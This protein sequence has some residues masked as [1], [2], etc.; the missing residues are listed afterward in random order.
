MK[1]IIR[2][3]IIMLAASALLAGISGCKKDG[4]TA[5]EVGREIDQTI[6]KAGQEVDEA[7]K[8]TGE[9]VDTAVKKTGR[10]IEK[11]GKKMQE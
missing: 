1:K 8:K 7:V 10:E 3:I 2:S 11:A 5:E 6:D 9:K 4:T